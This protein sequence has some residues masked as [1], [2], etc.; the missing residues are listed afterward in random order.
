MQI[1]NKQAPDLDQDLVDLD[2]LFGSGSPRNLMSIVTRLGVDLSFYETGT[3][4]APTVFY[5]R[6]TQ[7]HG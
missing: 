7:E 6:S 4:A 3:N 1:R 2:P 5:R